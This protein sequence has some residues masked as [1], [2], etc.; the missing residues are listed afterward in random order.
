MEILKLKCHNHNDYPLLYIKAEWLAINLGR[1]LECQK[2]NIP[3]KRL[4]QDLTK[5]PFCI[6]ARSC[7]ILQNP[8]GSCRI[9]HLAG[10]LCK[11]PARF[12]RILQDL[13]GMQEKG[14]FLV[15]SCKSVFTGIL[16]ATPALMHCLICLHS[17]SGAARWCRAYIPGN[18]LLPVLQLLFVF[19]LFYY[20]CAYAIL[21]LAITFWCVLINV[22]N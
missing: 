2:C 4:L 19:L 11:I 3:V 13:V 5:G 14:P 16:V 21:I 7:K 22:N 9:L 6:P 12:H 18:A 15:R 1:F 20:N 10:I 8:A 17:P